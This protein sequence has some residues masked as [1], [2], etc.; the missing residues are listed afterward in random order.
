MVLHL[1]VDIEALRATKLGMIIKGLSAKGGKGGTPGY[2][3][4]TEIM[5]LAD[6]IVSKWTSHLSTDSNS[7]SSNNSSSA[8]AAAGGARAKSSSESSSNLL[9]L[10]TLYSTPSLASASGKELDGAAAAAA[11][12]SRKRAKKETGKFQSVFW[13]FSNRMLATQC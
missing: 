4:S 10:G 13:K 7:S 3:D 8:T 11:E 5:E 9:P 6:K 2:E 1:P 12:R